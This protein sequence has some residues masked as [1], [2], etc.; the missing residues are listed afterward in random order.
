MPNK[1]IASFAAIFT[2]L[3]GIPANAEILKVRISG[4]GYVFY[5]GGSNTYVIAKTRPNNSIYI[6]HTTLKSNYWTGF[7]KWHDHALM[8]SRA[9]PMTKGEWASSKGCIIGD[10][11]VITF[12]KGEDPS[13]YTIDIK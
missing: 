2:L 5:D 9:C 12:P 6:Y 10:R 11:G 1:L 3:A 7:G 8:A 13:D 4:A